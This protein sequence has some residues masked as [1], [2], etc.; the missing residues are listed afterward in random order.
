MLLTVPLG[1]LIGMIIAAFIV[2]LHLSFSGCL[3]FVFAWM[4]ATVSGFPIAIIAPL[5]LVS[6]VP[7]YQQYR[8]IAFI[9]EYGIAWGT[10][11]FLFRKKRKGSENT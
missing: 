5:F 4:L 11:F 2:R 1:A 9:I 3:S 7:Y 10:L 8:F 6:T